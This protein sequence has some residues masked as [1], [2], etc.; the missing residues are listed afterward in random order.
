MMTSTET[1]LAVT[2]P[3]RSPGA[4][5]IL[6][7]DDEPKVIEVISYHLERDGYQVISASDGE[8]ALGC[9][10]SDAPDLIITD[11]MMPKIDGIQL[12]R[13]VKE[14]VGTHFIPV[15]MVTARGSRQTRLQG[16]EVGADDFVDK[17]VDSIEL[18]IRVRS[19][20]YTKQLH[21]EL[22]AY[23]LD[24]EKRV[25]ERTAEL[26]GAYEQLK[27]LDQLK[28]DFVG[29][30]SHELR[31]PLHQARSALFLLGEKGL[32]SKDRETALDLAEGALDA[33]SQLI[34]DILALSTYDEPQKELT[35]ISEIV[36]ASIKGLC[37]LPKR[38]HSKIETDIPADLP[39]VFVDRRGMIRVLH[40]LMDNGIKFSDGK[41][42]VVKSQRATE[43]VRISVK[44]EGIG[45]SKE[46]RR[47]L[48]ELLYQ[49]DTSV[50][51][52]YG[53][54][55][56][57]LTLSRLV[58]GAHDIDLD[59]KSKKGK[60]TTVSFTLPISEGKGEASSR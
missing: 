27:E 30:V 24:L 9:I 33:L 47:G 7:V 23:R 41:P 11:V 58:L 14:D 59:I 31:T 25:V 1:K 28:G 15:I 19:L 44:D 45:I 8:Q 6:I 22:E 4:C 57:G 56:L 54:L 38:R 42:I 32:S 34:D 16:I 5:K 21:D 17:P 20:L 46:E 39:L 55:G 43:G 12:C 3:R 53:G 52:R 50:T 40:H 36:E 35:S 51:R 10:A 48:V 18:S 49:A 29:N 13:R 2:L 26:Q 60:G 37:N